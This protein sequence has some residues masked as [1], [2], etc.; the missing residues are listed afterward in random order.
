MELDLHK[1]I[2]ELN[3]ML[4]FMVLAMN[5]SVGWRSSPGPAGGAA[6][7]YSGYGWAYGRTTGAIGYREPV[8]VLPVR[9]LQSAGVPVP[10]AAKITGLAAF[11][12]LV[13]LTLVFLRKRY[14]AVAGAMGA[15]F[16]AANPYFCYYAVRG[17]AEIF[18]ILFFV[19]FWYFVERND[20]GLKNMAAAA[21]CAVLAALSKLIFLFYVLAALA[22]WALYGRSARRLRFASYCALLS[23]I[24]ILPYPAAQSYVF[25]RP[26]SLQENLLR[27]WRNTALE[28]PILEAPFS[29]GPLGPAQF[30]F[31]EGFRASAARF[32]SGLKKAFLSGLPE[33]AFYKIELFFGLL[34]LV[35]LLM[36]NS[37]PFAYLFF[38]FILPTAF[39]A[40]ARQL[41][42]GEGIESRFYLAAF[43]FVCAYAGLGFQRLLD[44]LKQFLAPVRTDRSF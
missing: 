43:W 31:G 27:Q 37:G 12:V 34:G 21:I 35:F 3:I 1:K 32:V 10:L 19:A 36:E 38:V 22:L 39:I 8:P 23:C 14:G 30:M 44:V 17:P 6:A 13:L 4:V 11:A 33:L 26:L 15:M 5:V 20:P 2:A 41:A 42:V 18:P 29:G 40:S 24:L 9:L 16:L 7:S 28:G 25:G